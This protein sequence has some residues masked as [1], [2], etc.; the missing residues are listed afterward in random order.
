MIYPSTIWITIEIK[1]FHEPYGKK[2]R[3]MIKKTYGPSST[4]DV[5][6]ILDIPWTLDISV[7]LFYAMTSPRWPAGAT[8]NSAAWRWSQ[9][10]SFSWQ[11]GGRCWGK[12]GGSGKPSGNSMGI[13]LRYSYIHTYIHIHMEYWM[14][15]SNQKTVNLRCHASCRRY[16]RWSL[17]LVH[18]QLGCM[19]LCLLLCQRAGLEPLKLWCLWIA[20]IVENGTSNPGSAPR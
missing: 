5:P 19:S 3:K 10:R 7:L 1:M 15:Y 6:L 20:P 4:R 8:W 9:T 17:V 11:H 18:Q 13:W 2:D 14:W 12:F 16:L